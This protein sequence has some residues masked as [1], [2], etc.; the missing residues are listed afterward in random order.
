MEDKL[1]FVDFS[2]MSVCVFPL[3]S[4]NGYANK[5]DFFFSFYD[6]VLG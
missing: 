4:A 6:N 1:R 5:S 2:T 3:T